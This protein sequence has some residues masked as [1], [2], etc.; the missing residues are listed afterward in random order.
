MVSPSSMMGPSDWQT[1]TPHNRVQRRE[2]HM[3][4]DSRTPSNNPSH[5]LQVPAEWPIKTHFHTSPPQRHGAILWI[6]AHLVYYR[7]QHCHQPTLA[8]YANFMRRARWKAYRLTHWLKWVG[9]YLTI[10]ASR[11]DL[12][13]AKIDPA[14]L[15][16]STTCGNLRPHVSNLH[17]ASQVLTYLPHPRTTPHH[18]T[19]ESYQPTF[20]LDTIQLPIL[21][22]RK[23]Q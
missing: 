21:Y 15:W 16:S 23:G 10:I 5:K 3:G 17:T 11:P 6:L 4:L 12:I 14:C 18:P 2:G 13:V 19:Q 1:T 8:D 9:N 7:T 20:G 22:T